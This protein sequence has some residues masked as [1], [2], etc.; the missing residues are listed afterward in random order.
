VTAL[1]VIALGS[2]MNSDD[3]AALVAGDRLRDRG[4]EIVA[5]GRPGAGLLELL[6]P[7]RPTLI[8]D[9]VRRGAAPGAVV[10]LPLAE[11]AG[12]AVAGDGVSSHGL[13]PADALRLAR[14][15][16]RP[17]PPGVFLGIGGARFAPGS[18]LS[19]EVAAGIEALVG[20]AL[21]AVERL[22]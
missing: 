12:A 8:L 1:R 4:L 17:L 5:A 6:E 7:S 18:E 21:R 10:E 20:A 19:P 16:G 14:A 15:L 3:A 9:V 22:A 13:G 11:L 2:A